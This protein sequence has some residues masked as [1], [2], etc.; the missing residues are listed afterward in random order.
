MS[1][2]PRKPQTVQTANDLLDTRACEEPVRCRAPARERYR[3]ETLRTLAAA[4]ATPK[5]VSRFRQNATATSSR[6]WPVQDEAPAPL[7]SVGGELAPT[8]VKREDPPRCSRRRSTMRP[9]DELQKS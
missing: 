2:C 9:R 7:F 1:S 3:R 8:V 4:A 6:P 5:P